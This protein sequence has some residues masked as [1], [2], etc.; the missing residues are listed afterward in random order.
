[1]IMCSFAQRSAACPHYCRYIIYNYAVVR[2]LKRLCDS[3]QA[4]A[5]S[6]PRQLQ[7][8]LHNS[9]HLRVLPAAVDDGADTTA[10]ISGAA[11][12]IDAQPSRRRSRRRTA[13][14]SGS[15]SER[16][17]TVQQKRR[18]VHQPHE[19][20]QPPPDKQQPSR[21]RTRRTS[22]A[23][24]SRDAQ[25]TADSLQQTR[26]GRKLGL[27]VLLLQ[28]ARQSAAVPLQQPAGPALWSATT[29]QQQAPPFVSHLSPFWLLHQAPPH[30][31]QPQ[32]QHSSRWHTANSVATPQVG[33][34]AVPYSALPA[35]APSTPGTMRTSHKPMQSNDQDDLDWQQQQDS[36]LLQL[37]EL[38]ADRGIE[39]PELRGGQQRTQCPE[40]NN[41]SQ[42]ED[43]FAVKVDPDIG[44]AVWQCHRASCGFKGGVKLHQHSSQHHGEAYRDPVTGRRSHSISSSNNSVTGSGWLQDKVS[45]VA[46]LGQVQQGCLLQDCVALVHTV[47]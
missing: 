47:T 10:A 37:V 43:C 42:N 33:S 23:T 14:A 19:E 45:V 18:Q 1:M 7:Q 21:R 40:C 22:R 16:V 46:E 44:S 12:C 24:S 4:T 31:A 13:T 34:S 28:Q 39:L 17:E 5:C 8:Y 41:G 2:P 29:A 20:V 27:G 3:H 11:G 15:M 35:S 9:R 6:L 32:W 38:L 25:D 36:R 26:G 30:G